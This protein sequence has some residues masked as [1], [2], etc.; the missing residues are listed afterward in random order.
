[1]DTSSDHPSCSSSGAP[2]RALSHAGLVPLPRLYPLCHRAA[3]VSLEFVDRTD[4]GT[5]LGAALQGYET[6]NAV[7]IGLPRGGVVVA[8]AVASRLRLP[9]RALIARK[10]GA[11]GNPELAI[12]AV[13]ET[14]LRWI[15]YA[16]AREVGATERYIDREVALQLAEAERRRREYGEQSAPDILGGRTAIVVDDGIATGA[17]TLV[18]IQSAR[19]L[20][21][22]HVVLAVPVASPHAV[23][24]LTPYVDKAVVL[25]QPDP[26]LAVGIHYERFEQV[27]DREVMRYLTPAAEA[28][29]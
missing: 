24:M 21:A 19:N 12:G 22:S 2:F 23:R 4:A 26:F 18:A 7:V 10:V 8:H 28:G 25:A 11:P 3:A 14:G 5:R 15:H 29:D 13:S 1:V 16:L 17:T 27:D 9:L 6:A 20:G